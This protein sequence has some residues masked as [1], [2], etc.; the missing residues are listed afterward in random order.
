M[1]A[2]WKWLDEY[3]VD[4]PLHDM[5]TSYLQGKQYAERRKAKKE[6][7]KRQKKDE[8]FDEVDLNDEEQGFKPQAA[9]AEYKVFSSNEDEDDNDTM[10]NSEEDVGM[11]IYSNLRYN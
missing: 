5:M 4:W 9:L 2:K 11:T 7:W 8:D 10:D 1:K 6:L 3:D